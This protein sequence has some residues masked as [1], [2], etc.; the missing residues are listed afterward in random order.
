MNPDLLLLSRE[1]EN[2]QFP[3]EKKYLLNYFE[4]GIQ[5][6]FLKYYFVF[7]DFKNFTDHTGISVQP[8][9]LRNI[10]EK[11]RIIEEAH[12]QAKANFDMTLVLEIESGNFKF[13]KHRA[14]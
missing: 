10:H 3:K 6:A 14:K 8:K 9:W 13:N 4:S 11:L 7:H 2:Y 1:F 12:K 5:E